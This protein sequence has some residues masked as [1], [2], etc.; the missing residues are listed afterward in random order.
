MP[1][2]IYC[3]SSFILTFFTP[4]NQID[5]PRFST[6]R[7]PRPSGVGGGFFYGCSNHCHFK[8]HCDRY[9][10][11]QPPSPS[12]GDPPLSGGTYLQPVCRWDL[13]VAGLA[14]FSPAPSLPNFLTPKIACPIPTKFFDPKNR[15]PHPYQ[16]FWPQKSPALS[17]P[18][19]L[20]QKM[21]T[22]PDSSLNK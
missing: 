21:P 9:L 6:F 13:A 22:K 16:I 20:T 11:Y 10:R 15:L 7:W 2:S 17:L 1:F 18:N 14:W 8:P 19:F 4:L 5:E 3:K 12:R